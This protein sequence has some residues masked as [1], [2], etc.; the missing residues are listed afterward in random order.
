LIF[1]VLGVMSHDEVF[2]EIARFGVVPVIAM[3]SVEA[4][5]PLADALLE[6]GLPL[7]EVT[8]RTAAA[9]AVISVMT[10]ERPELLVGAGTLLSVE[11]V[12]AAQSAGARFGVA[13]GLNPKVAEQAM[14]AGLPFAPGVCTPSDIERALELGCRVV[15]F[16]PAEASGGAEMVKAL[17]GPYCHLGLRF[18]PT[19]GIHLGNLETYLALKDV[20]AVG[21]TWIAKSEDFAAGRWQAIRERCREVVELVRRVRGRPT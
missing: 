13:P 12:R 4:A 18:I 3:E 20:V 15:K 1:K 19:G 5:L 10:R 9:A 21:G 7:A 14:H 11:N 16:F 17:S 8:F 2:A 6:G